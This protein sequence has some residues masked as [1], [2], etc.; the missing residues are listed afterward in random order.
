MDNWLTIKDLSQYLQISELKIRYLIKNKQIPYCDNHGFLRFNRQEIDEWMKA[1]VVSERKEKSGYS[2]DE[3]KKL[4]LADLHPE[5]DLPFIMK[6]FERIY[7]GQ[8]TFVKGIPLKR[9]DGSVFFADIS[10][11]SP[12]TLAGRKYLIGV[13][14]DITKRKEMQEA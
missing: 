10:S 3:I 4:Q 5:K 8:Q 13:F 2:A 14:R 9:K 1:P 12:I 7:A 6:Q 11:S